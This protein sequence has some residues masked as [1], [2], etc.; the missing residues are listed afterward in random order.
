MSNHIRILFVLPGFS[1]GGTTSSLVSLLN[2]EFSE[3]FDIEIFTINKRD[4]NPEPL[5]CYDIGSNNLTTA[6]YSSFSS[7]RIV[8]RLKYLPI[9]ILKKVSLL[10]SVLEKWVINRTIKQIENRKR[11]D[12]VVSFQEERTTWFTVN[13]HCPNK[14]AWI[15]CDYA[16]SFGKEVDELAIYNHYQKI[17]C[18]SDYT[19]R[20]FLGRYPS[21]E[22]K[23]VAI[24]NLFDASTVIARSKE[25]IDDFRFD[26][27]KFTIISLGRV[28][29]VKRFYLIP[30]IAESLKMAQMS[31]YWYIL[32][33]AGNEIEYERLTKAISECG[34]ENEVFFLGGKSNPYP[35]LKASDLL[36]SVSRSEAC[37]MI[38]NEARLLNIPILTTNFGSASEFVNDGEDG[39]ISTIEDMPNRIINIA[40]HREH[41]EAINKGF[42]ISDMNDDILKKIIGLFK[43]DNDF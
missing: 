12:Y 23:T 20:G 24:H 26:N 35:Y 21:L 11:Y 6:F 8:D 30:E 22:M 36:V 28:C 2:S 5:S 7:F 19:R 27:S 37:P 13:F 16:K 15:H 39:F 38:F 33:N 4:Y 29:D 10:Y 3:Q 40:S 17:V 25:D 34:V 42:V 41:V 14:I 9:K 31:F 32:G 43:N 18:V 1:I